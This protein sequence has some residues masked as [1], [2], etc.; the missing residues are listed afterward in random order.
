[1]KTCGK[2]KE[3][4]PFSGFIKKSRNKDGR[5][6]ACKVCTRKGVR[7]HYKRNRQ[8]YIDKAARHVKR[9][10]EMVQ[11]IKEESGCI[12]CDTDYPYFVLEFDHR[13]PTKKVNC[14][15]TL[16]SNGYSEKAILNEIKKCDVVCSNCHRI[17]THASVSPLPSKQ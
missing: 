15:A 6:S 1:M 7:D 12:D 14:V 4:K 9:M 11:A 8:K 16:V 10:R 2:C 3:T 17:R 5:A 13:E